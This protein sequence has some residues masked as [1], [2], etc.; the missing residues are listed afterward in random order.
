MGKHKT[1]IEIFLAGVQANK[2]ARE[3]SCREHA[4]SIVFSDFED[5]RRR[6]KHTKISDIFGVGE[7]EHVM[8]F[9]DPNKSVIKSWVTQ[10]NCETGLPLPEQTDSFC[11]W[12]RHG[13]KE[14]PIGL[15]IRYSKKEGSFETEGIF[16]SFSCCLAFWESERYCPQYRQSR[17]LLHL[18]YEH[19]F[20]H[21]ATIIAAPSWKLLQK[22]NGSMTI[23]EYRKK[24]G[25]S[26]FYVTGNRY[27]QILFPS[28]EMIEER[29][30]F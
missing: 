3:F 15:P 9:L 7:Q 16:C 10:I 24:L 29:R 6:G 8:V 1:P 21:R 18:L 11:W 20:R 5:D 22:Y 28:G 12:C 30:R 13:F 19:F 27:R 4:E 26:R 25:K 17:E 2:V 14:C 23:E